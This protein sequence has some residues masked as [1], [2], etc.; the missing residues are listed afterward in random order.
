MRNQNKKAEYV[1]V[2]ALDK[3]NRSKVKNYYAPLWGPELASAL[4]YDWKPE[5][6]QLKVKAKNT[7]P[8]ITQS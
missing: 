7:N 6:K 5:G 3:E 1:K 4:V 8:F 2:A